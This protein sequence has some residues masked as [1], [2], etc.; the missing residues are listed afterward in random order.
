MI[1]QDALTKKFTGISFN[2]NATDCDEVEFQAVYD[3]ASAK[4]TK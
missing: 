3:A 4:G 2:L 1:C